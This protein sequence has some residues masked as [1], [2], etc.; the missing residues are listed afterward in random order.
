MVSEFHHPLPF[1][2][3]VLSLCLAR[4]SSC[5]SIKRFPLIYSKFLNHVSHKSYSQYL[6]SSTFWKKVQELLPFSLHQSF[7]IFFT[8]L[9][10]TGNSTKVIWGNCCNPF[11]DSK[12]NE[13]LFYADADMKCFIQPFIPHIF[14]KPWKIIRKSLQYFKVTYIRLLHARRFCILE[15]RGLIKI[16]QNFSKTKHIHTE[17]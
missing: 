7:K 14:W 8:V 5:S 9:T 17:S 4:W 16:T 2:E 6:L 10:F 1:E 12:C 11:H 3:K 15:V 13:M